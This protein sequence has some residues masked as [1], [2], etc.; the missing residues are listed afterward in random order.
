MSSRRSRSGGSWIVHDVEPVVQVLAELPLVDASCQVAVGGGDDA[1][2]DLDVSLP[3]TRSNSPLL[4]HAQQL[5]LHRRRH[6]ADL[7]EEERAAVGQLEAA[8]A[9]PIAPVNAPFSWPKSSL[10]SSV[11]G[12]AAQFT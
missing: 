2:V 1:H 5:R 9:L 4:Q 10:S 8:R 3:P 11:S 6:V 7:V 12:S